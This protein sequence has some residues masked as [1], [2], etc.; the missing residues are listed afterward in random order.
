MYGSLSEYLGQSQKNAGFFGFY[1][2]INSEC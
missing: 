2:I 1:L